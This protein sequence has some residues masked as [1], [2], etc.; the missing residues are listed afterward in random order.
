MKDVVEV[1]KRKMELCPFRTN[2]LAGRITLEQA[3]HK[4]A[5]HASFHRSPSPARPLL[6]IERRKRP[7]RLDRRH[8]RAMVNRGTISFLSLAVPT[9]IIPLVLHKP[10]KH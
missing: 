5:F 8:E 10:S 9:S 2:H 4:H 1:E 3:L 7:Q 6:G